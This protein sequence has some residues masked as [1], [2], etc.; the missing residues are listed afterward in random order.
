MYGI[1]R[2]PLKCCAKDG[3]PYRT[4]ITSPNSGNLGSS[5]ICARNEQCHG[6]GHSYWNNSMSLSLIAKEFWSTDIFIVERSNNGVTVEGGPQEWK[7]GGDLTGL[8]PDSDEIPEAPK[9]AA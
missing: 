1:Q 7:F 8:V 3:N 4:T 9:P 2:Q 6:K 5:A